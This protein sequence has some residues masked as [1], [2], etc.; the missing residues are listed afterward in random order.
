MQQLWQMERDFIDPAT[1]AVVVIR[2]ANSGGPGGPPGPLAL[3][4]P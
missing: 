4:I 2:D 1:R 3:V